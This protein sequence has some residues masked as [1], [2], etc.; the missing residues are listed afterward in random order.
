MR[1]ADLNW[2]IGLGLASFVQITMTSL[3][4]VL[5]ARSGRMANEN[6]PRVARCRC[7]GD[8]VRQ[9]TERS[10]QETW[11]WRAAV[12][13][14]LSLDFPVEGE[15]CL[16]YRRLG[17]DAFIRLQ[18]GLRIDDSDPDKPKRPLFRIH[19]EEYGFSRNLVGLLGLWF[20]SLCV[21]IVVTGVQAA[22]GRAPLALLVVELLFFAC[23]VMV[24][25]ARESFVMTGAERL[26]ESLLFAAVEEAHVDSASGSATPPQ[27]SGPYPQCE[28][29]G[30][31][32]SG[33]DGLPPAV[34]T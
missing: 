26:S 9:D 7:S 20:L 32:W 17:R 22:S 19:Q 3:S 16:T 13:K 11:Q 28:T 1:P 23:W 33:P 24:L 12:K 30:S 14:L 5:V 8:S 21:G 18:A 6:S 27:L 31:P 4:R 34:G 29:C 10:L 2:L 25:A 15:D